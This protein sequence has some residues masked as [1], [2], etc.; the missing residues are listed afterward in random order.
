MLGLALAAIGV[1]MGFVL[2]GG[3]DGGRAGHGLAVALGWVLGRARV[4]APVTLVAA[5]GVL[6]L[7]PVLPALRPLRA[8]VICLFAS[9]TLALAAGTLG[10]SSGSA[11]ARQPVDVG[12]SCSRTAGSPARRSSRRP[13]G[14]CRAWA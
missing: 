9:V 10:V 4:L 13:T 3:G 6:L 12:P 14:S 8:G 2:Y 7:R 5:G 1:F 11:G